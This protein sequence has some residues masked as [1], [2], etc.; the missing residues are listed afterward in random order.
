MFEHALGRCRDLSN[1]QK[2]GNS[3]NYNSCEGEDSTLEYFSR[4]HIIPHAGSALRQS[5]RIEM[6]R[7]S[8]VILLD[9]MASGRVAHG[10]RWSFREM[11]SRTEVYS[12]GRPAY[13]NRMRIVPATSRPDRLGWMGEFD[14]LSSMGLHADGFLRWPQVAA[15]LNEELKSLTNVQGATT[16]LARGGCVVRFLA[17]FVRPTRARVNKTLWDAARAEVAGLP[18][19]DH[20]KY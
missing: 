10:E 12:C 5:L 11:D 15:A 7:G 9:S 14:Y 17:L 3:R 19:F 2:A 6:A 16:V 13:I 20:R 1:L 18:P 8:R 4:S